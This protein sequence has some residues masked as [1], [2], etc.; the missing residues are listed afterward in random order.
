MTRSLTSN[1][2]IAKIA[3]LL[4]A[5]LFVSPHAEHNKTDIAGHWAGA[6]T[7]Y[8][9]V[10]E[11]TI[12][13]QETDTGWV[14]SYDIPDLILYREPIPDIVVT[15][16]TLAFRVFWGSFTCLIHDEIGEIT[17]ENR[18]WNPP[19]SIH[20]K[21]GPDL[22]HMR[23]EK[24][25][26]PS[27][28]L[29]L[30]ADLLIPDGR[31]PFPAVIV[32]EGSTT[33]GRA[34]W[35]YRSIGD[36]FARNGIAALIY[37]KRGVGQ[38]DGNI[39]SVT[40]DD[41]ASDAVNAVQYLTNRDDIDSE[42]IGLVGISQG[43]WL[44][45]LAANRS[46]HVSF[47]VLL[48]GPAV[49]IWQQELHRVEYSMRTGFYGEDEPDVFSEEEIEAAIAHTRLG[50]DVAQNPEKWKDWEI[51]VVSAKST[52]WADYVRLDSTLNDLQGWLRFRYEPSEVLQKLR[53]PA[54][55]IFGGD[56]VFVPPA[57][58]VPLLER[59]LSAAGNKRSRVVVFANVGHDFFAG[60]TLVGRE[61]AWPSGFWRWNRRA[62]GLAD[63]IIS[64]SRQQVLR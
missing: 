55:A 6:F 17:G 57:E 47:V 7:R 14:G 12:D 63:T 49:S 50:F 9:A 39:D 38:S 15:A 37:D 59:Y 58:N 30:A 3:V 42:S 16:E 26:F 43:G 54:L 23:T 2:R 1:P 40:I 10:Q 51:S 48:A 31:P 33:E 22:H 61:W 4:L 60:A 21:R 56:D 35:T 20:L 64:W 11:I 29:L 32:I 18:N 28:S 27:E 13:F 19:V 46:G 24:V 44:A 8:G 45:P 36:L 34:L 41:L 53:I 52:S 62:V 5:G 25:Q